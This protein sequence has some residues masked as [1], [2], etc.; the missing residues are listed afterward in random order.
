MVKQG[1]IILLNFDLQAGH[2]QNGCRPA[3]VI[4]NNT[5][6]KYSK[7]FMVCPIS[8]TDKDHPFHILLDDRTKTTGVIL[9]DQTRTLDIQVRNFEFKEYLPDEILNKVINLLTS[10]IRNPEK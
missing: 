8:H 9:C 4:S 5:F 7:M 3:L 1:D 6:N 2:E 10:F